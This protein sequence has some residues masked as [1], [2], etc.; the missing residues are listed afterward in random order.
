MIIKTTKRGFKYLQIGDEST[1][2]IFQ[3]SSAV[4]DYEDSLDRPGS[5]YLWFRDVH[6]DRERVGQLVELLQLWLKGELKEDL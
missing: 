3:E 1:D 4:G 2:I 5:S 6:M